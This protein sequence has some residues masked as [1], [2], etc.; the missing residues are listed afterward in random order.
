MQTIYKEVLDTFWC[1]LT[2]II[3][4][5]NN[6]TIFF[7]LTVCLIPSFVTQF[8]EMSNYIALVSV[9]LIIGE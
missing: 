3:I 7:Y 9:I 8:D 6:K 1:V 4:N 5:N 2:E